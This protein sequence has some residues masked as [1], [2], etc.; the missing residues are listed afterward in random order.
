MYKQPLPWRGCGAGSVAL[1]SRA[2]KQAVLCLAAAACLAA[3]DSSL[4]D[5]VKRRDPKSVESLIK[6]KADVNAAQ[7]DG[8]TALAWA[9]HLGD[10]RMAEMLLA[11][12]SEE[13]TSELQSRRD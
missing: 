6:Q 5:A 1:L 13:H 2:R 8:G 12:R 3:A 11:A 9:V 10:T 4:L 7:P